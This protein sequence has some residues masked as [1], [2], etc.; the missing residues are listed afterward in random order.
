MKVKHVDIHQLWI[1][2]EVAAGR[3][4]VIWVPTNEMLAD[5]LTKILPRQKFQEFVRLLELTDV[6]SCLRTMQ[7]TAIHDVNILY[8]N[9][10]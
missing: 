1:W 10:S 5:R 6:S 9:C 3:L 2:Q 4:D 8:P 7:A